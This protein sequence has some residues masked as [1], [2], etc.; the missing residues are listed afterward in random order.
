MP[1]SIYIEA[2]EK[3]CQEYEKG[4]HIAV[5]ETC[6]KCKLWYR[7]DLSFNYCKECP[8][9]AFCRT[10]GVGCVFRDNLA[11][12]SKNL[13]AAER[14]SMIEYH[15]EVINLIKTSPKWDWDELEKVKSKL[16]EIDSHLYT[17]FVIGVIGC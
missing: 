15:K 2:Y 11:K 1:K 5:Q 3:T 12:N 8:E 9:T 13:D 16:P 17:I 14:A 10:G 7:P 4:T 6:H